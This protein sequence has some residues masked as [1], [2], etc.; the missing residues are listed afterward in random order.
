MAQRSA[1]SPPAGNPLPGWADAFGSLL[2]IVW[3][4]AGDLTLKLLARVEGCDPKTRLEVHT[5]ER[6]W[7]IP[8]NC[9]GIDLAGDG[10][11]LV[12][13]Q[14]DA[15]LFGLLDTLAPAD[16]GRGIGIGVL[17]IALVAT[18]FVLRWRWRS[19][20]DGV[21]LG[22]LWA[23]AIAHGF[24]YA[25]GAGTSFTELSIAG[26]GTGVADLALVWAALWLGWRF[27]AEAR[28]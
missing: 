14:R 23:G 21:A 18:Y 10:F 12:P 15:D 20:G 5:L 26:V 17:V 3:L 6:V 27:V 25:S 19:T 1:G 11:R 13:Q 22:A 24:P 8:K 28:A 2:L 9:P 4:I 16:A 7:E